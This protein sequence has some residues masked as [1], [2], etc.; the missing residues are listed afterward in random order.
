MSINPTLRLTS[1]CRRE[2]AKMN[3]YSNRFRDLFNIFWEGVVPAIFTIAAILVGLV[4]LAG[5]IEYVGTKG[6]RQHSDPTLS[7]QV[8]TS[9]FGHST[10]HLGVFHTTSTK[11]IN[12]KIHVVITGD[13]LSEGRAIADRAFE[14]WAQNEEA[15]I[16]FDFPIQRTNDLELSVTVTITSENTQETI[17][18]GQWNGDGWEKR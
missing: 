1:F 18:F 9:L 17:T 3:N 8:S 16:Y 13:A 10:F 7:G 2:N 14:S 15:A 11:L 6:W 4:I 5:A 12:G